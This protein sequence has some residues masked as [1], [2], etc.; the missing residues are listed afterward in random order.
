MAHHLPR[1]EHSL[2]RWLRGLNRAAGRMNPFLIVL[3]IGLVI[4]N[5]VCLAL[6]APHLTITRH[7][8]GVGDVPVSLGSIPFTAT[9]VGEGRQLTAH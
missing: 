8:P 5:L 2:D 4:L 3:A 1:P 6:L 7:V 9:E